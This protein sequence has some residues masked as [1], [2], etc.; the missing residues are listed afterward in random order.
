MIEVQA[1]VGLIQLRKLDE[2]NN[3]RNDNAAYLTGRLEN[4]DGIEPPYVSE[5]VRH[6]FWVYTI[7][8]KEDLL[9]IS[10]NRFRQALLA[11]GVMSA[12]F[13]SSPNYRQPFL[14]KQKGHGDS[15]CP[16]QCPL[17]KGSVDY[18]KVRLP[19]TEQACK[20]VVNLPVHNLLTKEELKVVADAVEKVASRN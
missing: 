3:R 4:I 19:V 11:E 18:S 10:R 14:L 17:Y 16:F 13:Y 1:A 8:I 9:G 6:N 7:R 12:G 15:N 5:K 20:E 2:F